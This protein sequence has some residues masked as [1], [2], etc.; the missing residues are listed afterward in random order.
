MLD[1]YTR[2]ILAHKLQRDMTADSFI[3]VVQ[4][5]VD[6]TG[7]TDV[8][9]EDRTRLLSDNGAQGMCLARSETT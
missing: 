4:D 2:F 7:M 5:A 3:E 8:P 9:V 6:K 1:D